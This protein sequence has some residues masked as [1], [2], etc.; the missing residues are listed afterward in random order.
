MFNSDK[1][2]ME[3]KLSNQIQATTK[4][5]ATASASSKSKRAIDPTAAS[6]RASNASGAPMSPVSS[7]MAATK[8]GNKKR[9]TMAL[10]SLSMEQVHMVSI[11]SIDSVLMKL[12][13]TCVAVM[14]PS[15]RVITAMLSGVGTLVYWHEESKYMVLKTSP[16]DWVVASLVIL[17][18]VA[19]I[20]LYSEAAECER[21]VEIKGDTMLVEMCTHD[22]G[23]TFN[24]IRLPGHKAAGSVLIVKQE[25]RVKLIPGCR[26]PSLSS[27][28][29]VLTY[30]ATTASA[31]RSDSA[32]GP[33][34][35]EIGAA[36]KVHMCNFFPAD[37]NTRKKQPLHRLRLSASASSESVPTCIQP[38]NSDLSLAFE[39]TTGHSYLLFNKAHLQKSAIN[40]ED[41]SGFMAYTS[42]PIHSNA[43]ETGPLE[44]C[45][46]VTNNGSF[47]R[48]TYRTSSGDT[49]A[50]Q[51]KLELVRS[52]DNNATVNLNTTILPTARDTTIAL[53]S[54][55]TASLLLVPESCIVIYI[56]INGAVSR[57]VDSTG[58][59]LFL[60]ENQF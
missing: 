57:Q 8:Q 55:S 16:S 36:E 19:R 18:T 21:I 22:G 5:N 59:E 6:Q 34:H 40:P 53:N 46:V 48:G 2:L 45:P 29:S 54:V 4:G 11:E 41:G 9:F 47:V 25:D 60:C 30:W 23:T 1:R 56:D 7:S 35:S 15:K 20:P 44:H 3:T 50:N 27:D 12:S 51:A 42:M 32:A 37:N 28:G 10:R 13:D 26:Q 31:G 17:K 24:L 38:I 52:P 14:C 49:W 58:G 33:D 43:I 39:T